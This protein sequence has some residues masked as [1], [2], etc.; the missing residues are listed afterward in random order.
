MTNERTPFTLEYYVAW[1]EDEL[2]K[3]SVR[4]DQFSVEYMK[5][6][7][8]RYDRTL[9]FLDQCS[10]DRALEI[11]ATDFFQVY[12]KNS[13]AFEDVWG[14]IFS[15][16]INEK[17][18]KK[19]FSAAGFETT[20][21]IVSLNLEH[22]LFPVSEEHFDLV[23]LC[24]V[25]EHMDI[26]PMFCLNEIN[27]ILKPAGTL[28]LT[29]PNSCSAR[30][31][32]KAC[33]GYRPH[34]FMQYEKDRSPYRHNFEHDVHS[35]SALVEAAGFAVECLETHDVFEPPHQ[36]AIEF[37]KRNDMPLHHRGDDIFIVARKAGAPRD[38]WPSTLYV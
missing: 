34:F 12:L 3:G 33:L 19:S 23:M 18:Y 36:E 2:A 15:T 6:H 9:T 20:N 17:F 28:I 16:N 38:R 22:E 11:G 7:Q 8:P 35:L 13:R 24:E 10:G 25:I 37:L 1:L 30:I 14:T 31:A 26:D 4:Y 29:T 32:Y 21:S 27:R 5:S